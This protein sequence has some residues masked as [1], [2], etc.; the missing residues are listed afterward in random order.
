MTE[1]RTPDADG[2][3]AAAARLKGHAVRTPLIENA[4]LNERIG[5]RALLKAECLQRCGAFKYRGARNLL[6]ALGPGGR[7]RGV[8]A[9]SSGNH[10]H[11]VAR[12]ASEF[13][14]TA[15]IVMPEDAPALKAQMVRHYGATIVTYDRYR[16]DREAIAFDIIKRTGAAVAP[17]F[18]HP[19][20][21]E[22]Q[23]T[24][25]LEAAEQAKAIGVA[26]DAFLVCAGGG[27][28]AAGCALAFEAAAPAT[29][30]WTAEPEGYDDLKMSLETGERVAVDVSRPTIC[31]AI[32]T[33]T[34]G[35]I[36]FPVLK[37]LAGGGVAVSEADVADAMAFAFDHLKLAVEPGGAVA[38]AALLS[39]RFD[40]RGKTVGATLSG[41]NVDAAV[42]ARLVAR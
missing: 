39:R 5:G 23:G 34:P 33:P 22:G 30:V 4:V 9:W 21:I 28:L 14:A 18:D 13:D 29:K 36:T 40:A 25:G 2:V 31:D 3:Y 35:A 6:D 41:G 11:G 16:D 37:R 32:A 8:V 15:T 38:L 20:I 24:A 7:A 17:S 26:F 10:G 19:D 12:A 42:F 27:G 1:P